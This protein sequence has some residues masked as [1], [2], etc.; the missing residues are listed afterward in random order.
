MNG[1][2]VV[3]PAGAVELLAPAAGWAGAATGYRRGA[4]VGEDQGAVHTGFVINELEPGG[5]IP[6]H[7]HSF[8]ESR[9][10]WRVRR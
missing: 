5:S 7:V 8:E 10:W 2:H 3:R 1:G 9:T 4:A 6:W